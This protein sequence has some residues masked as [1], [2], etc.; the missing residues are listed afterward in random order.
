MS[1]PILEAMRERIRERIKAERLLE[2]ERSANSYHQA[3][4]TG[5]GILGA[6]RRLLDA[7]V[8]YAD[9]ANLTT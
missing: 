1:D 7:A 6:K 5:S 4:H 3:K 9:A 2:L 8:S